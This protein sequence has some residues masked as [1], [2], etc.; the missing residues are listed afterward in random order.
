MDWEAGSLR[1]QVGYLD[2]APT[3]STRNGGGDRLSHA[4]VLGLHSARALP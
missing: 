1:L 2:K 3:F 4:R